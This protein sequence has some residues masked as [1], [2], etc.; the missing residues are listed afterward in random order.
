MRNNVYISSLFYKYKRSSSKKNCNQSAVDCVRISLG[1]TGCKVTAQ[2]LCIS[3]QL[4]ET[5][6]IINYLNTFVPSD[7]RSLG[8]SHKSSCL[9]SLDWCPQKRAPYK[10]SNRRWRSQECHNV[11]LL[12]DPGMVP[13][14]L[15]IGH[16]ALQ[17]VCVSAWNH[18]RSHMFH[19]IFL[20]I[21]ILKQICY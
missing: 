4:A 18:R 20:L 13:W 9:L 7:Q 11:R 3:P 19:N 2:P 12:G 1:E 16:L 15:A 14:G 21:K 8:R 6:S 17:N 10:G 5:T